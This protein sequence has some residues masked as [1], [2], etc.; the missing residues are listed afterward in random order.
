MVRITSSRLDT[1]IPLGLKYEISGLHPTCLHLNGLG[2]I[3]SGN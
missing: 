2:I 3:Y 1:G